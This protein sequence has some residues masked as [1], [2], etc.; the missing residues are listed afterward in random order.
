MRIL[1]AIV[2][3]VLV[4]ALLFEGPGAGL[5]LLV[6]LVGGLIWYGRAREAKQAQ[7]APAA[8]PRPP[9][10]LELL[11]ARLAAI[12]ERLARLEGGEAAV[13]L[14]RRDAG[15][16]SASAA[17]PAAMRTAAP[18]TAAASAAYAAAG[19][20]MSG[21]GGVSIAAT[22][23]PA[24]DAAGAG[25]PASVSDTSV[26]TAA[27]PGPATGSPVFPPPPRPAGPT[28]LQRLLSGNL[29]A[30]L[31]IV[32]LFFGVSFLIKFALENA[33]VPVEIWFA[34]AALGGAVLLA[35]GWRLRQRQG[36]FGLILQG[37][38]IGVLY[39]VIF[40]A[41]K[42][43]QLLPPTFAFALLV[44]VVALA[45][46]L[47]VLQDALALAVVGVSGGFLA[48]ILVSTGQGNHIALF[49][50]Y[51]IL[52]AGIFAIAWHKAW[53]I[54]N[55]L[56]FVFTAGIGILWG[57]H[58]YRPEL[59]ASTEAF[60]ILFV[61]MYVAIAVLFALRQAP[62]LKHYVDG[63]IVFGTPILGFGLQAGIIRHIEYGMAFSAL[64]LGLGYLVLAALLY[65]RRRETLRLLVESFFALALIFGT[66]AI[67][68]ALDARWTSAAWAVEGAAVLWAGI[69]QHRLLARFFGLLLQL[70]AALAFVAHAQHGLSGAV[71]V[72]NSS[73][74][75]M[76]MI[77]LA[78]LFSALQLH[79]AQGVVRPEE[80][81]L[82]ALLFV[83][84][85]LWWLGLGITETDRH[86]PEPW[87]QCAGLLFVAL[88][89][90]A[91]SVAAR[92]LDWPIARWPALALLPFLVLIALSTPD[93]PLAGGGWAAWPLA[94]AAHYWLLR[95]HAADETEPR[96]RGWISW[97]HTGSALLVALLGSWELHWWPAESGLA[98]SAWTVAAAMVVP[99]LLLAWISRPAA[100]HWPLEPYRRE[101]L[102]RAGRV[103]ALALVMWMWF[104]NIAHDGS[105]APLPYMPLLNALDLGHILGGIAIAM[106]LL[107]L[108]HADVGAA[109]PGRADFL[110]GIAGATAF[111][112]LNGILLRTL[113]HWAGIPYEFDAMW[114]SLLVQAALSLFWTVLAFALML[115]ARQRRLRVPWMVGAT[116]MGIV[117]L[118]LFLVDLSQ[119]SGIERIVSF[120]GVGV[121]MLLMGYFVPLPPRTDDIAAEETAA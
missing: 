63:T 117:V 45:A 39:L 27:A 64:A 61:V 76:L 110:Y 47:A 52:N 121:L 26:E 58:S 33:I 31:G 34:L 17:A 113:H 9:T 69:R 95:W 66:L 87:L 13:A 94:L 11:K 108:R 21:P 4:G 68:L 101:Y 105:S 51:A 75:G 72:L 42:L 70:L 111:V 23:A 53:R 16:A 18:A 62:N 109:L 8:A 99:A 60:L 59:F 112:W 30:K 82:G 84:G 91:F 71:P 85:C 89:G 6:G 56:G 86:V 115:V 29:V 118:K 38:G 92:R 5:G 46:I 10:E 98:H 20:S 93:H 12:E 79:R 88:S 7:G 3:G 50:Y 24:A 32:I 119:L 25:I 36:G 81:M 120:L 74:L 107:R 65:A 48:P 2:L 97:M 102:L 43:Y 103:L 28:L 73:G 22:T 55:V 96:T 77:A 41:L 40:G 104:A 106:W 15:A 57:Q 14:Q 90:L 54:L 83:W 37:G 44:A 67:P 35:I 19:A 100:T 114:N 78:A 49:T 1:I 116:L 80:G